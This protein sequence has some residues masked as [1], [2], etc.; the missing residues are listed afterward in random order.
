MQYAPPHMWI[1]APPEVWRT[2]T[3]DY[4]AANEY[5]EAHYPRW[6]ASGYFTPSYSCQPIYNARHGVYDDSLGALVPASLAGCGFAL[7]RPGTE[8]KVAD[9]DDAT[10]V[11]ATYLPELR[12]LITE[13]VDQSQAHD[14]V[15]D[16]IF[17]HM[18]IRQQGSP[19]V[20]P[21]DPSGGA[22][23]RGPI[24]SMAHVDTDALCCKSRAASADRA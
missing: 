21:A 10:E 24:A 2:A 13:A 6:H 8:A 19:Y 9:W 7:L 5:V 11:R 22:V 4:S 20:G 23:S 17:W 16:I 15:R 1:A 18:L 3:I 14:K 12:R